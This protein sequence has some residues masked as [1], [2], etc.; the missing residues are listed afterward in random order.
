MAGRLKSV[1]SGLLL[2]KPSTAS[3]A[4]VRTVKHCGLLPDISGK[5][6]TVSSDVGREASFDIEAG[7]S[8]ASHLCLNP[9][10]FFKARASL[11]YSFSW[12][13]IDL[14]FSKWSVPCFCL[15]LSILHVFGLFLFWFYLVSIPLDLPILGLVSS[16]IPYHRYFS[17]NFISPL[18]SW[19]AT[20]LFISG[21]RMWNLTLPRPF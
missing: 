7:T 12:F 9:L 16:F 8:L 2:R 19:S 13:F 4:L 11:Q 3:S 20:F 21:A 17:H 5:T 10:E 18:K 14:G 1:W 15:N 6:L